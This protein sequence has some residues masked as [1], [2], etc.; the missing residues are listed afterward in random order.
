MGEKSYTELVLVKEEVGAETFLE[1]AAFVAVFEGHSGLQW[2]E[3]MK[4]P[5]EDRKEPWGHFHGGGCKAAPW[6]LV[7]DVGSVQAAEPAEQ[8]GHVDR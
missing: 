7:Q 1:V 6:S 3:G 8:A 5:A 2:V 4:C